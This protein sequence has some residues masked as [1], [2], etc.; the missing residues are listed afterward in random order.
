MNAVVEDEAVVEPVEEEVNEIEESVDTDEVE[1]DDETE[2]EGSEETAKKEEESE[3][4]ESSTSKK[5]DGFQKRI[6]EL[7]QRY[8]TEKEQ[9]E[10]FQR[11]WEDSQT[12]VVAQEPGKTLADFDYDEPAWMSYQR[13]Q[14][15]N[16]VRAD[17]QRKSDQQSEFQRR[18]E[19]SA[20]EAKLAETVPDYYKV[21]HHSPISPEVAGIIMSAE[22]AP[23]LAYYV[24]KNPELAEKLSAM[25]PLDAARELGRIEVTKL[26]KP[27]PSNK[28]VPKAVPKVKANDTGAS[29]IKSDSPESD[30]LSTEEWQRRELKRL[31][32]RNK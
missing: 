18:G 14:M 25:N 9:R 12:P 24:G 19:F 10:H 23:E 2:A 20:K 8:Y 3:P 29:R 16:E 5:D 28:E 4:E 1:A 21:A 17:I 32:N 31:A 15:A 7:T 13:E 27:E 22:K 26:I 30:K 11:Q 6:D